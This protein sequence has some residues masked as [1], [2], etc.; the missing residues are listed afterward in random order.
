[1]Q[2]LRLSRALESLHRHCH[3]ELDEQ[4]VPLYEFMQSFHCENVSLAINDPPEG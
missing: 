3:P 2:L 1:M 4:V